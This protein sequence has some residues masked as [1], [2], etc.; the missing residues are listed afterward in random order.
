MALPKTRTLGAL[1]FAL[2]ISATPYM[3]ATRET[4]QPLQRLASPPAEIVPADT[5]AGPR[6]QPISTPRKPEAAVSEPRAASEEHAATI[7]RTM[8]EFFSAQW[9][10]DLVNALV[11]R[12]LAPADSEQLAQRYVDGI[13]DCVFEAARKEYEARGKPDGDDVSWWQVMAYSNLNR[14]QSAAVPC[15]ANI[16]QQTGIP[17]PAN[18]GSGGVV[19]DD[20][21]AEPPSPPWAAEMEARIRDYVASYSSPDIE[22]V[23]VKC[24]EQGCTVALVGRD[25]RIFDFEFDVFAE[26]NGFKHALVSGAPNSRRVWLER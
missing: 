7:K 25:V 3:L 4:S 9:R 11:E 14:V 12:G 10:E 19:S 22:T 5:I 18:F 13:V 2:V 20:I 16:S 1:A 21:R 15:V 6:E 8:T 24:V 23:L 26:Q 17:P